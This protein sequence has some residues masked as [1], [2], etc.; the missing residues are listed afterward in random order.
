MFHLIL[1]CIYIYMNVSYLNKLVCVTVMYCSINSACIHNLYSCNPQ[2][3]LSLICYY[4]H[5]QMWTSLRWV[6][7]CPFHIPSGRKSHSYTK[8]NF[9]LTF[10][11]VRSNY[12]LCIISVKYVYFLFEGDK[13]NNTLLYLIFT[14]SEFFNWNFKISTL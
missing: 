2:Y 9:G 14:F 13:K 12:I 1:E 10:Y 7:W 6:C 8:E 4:F 3:I 11:C 5:P